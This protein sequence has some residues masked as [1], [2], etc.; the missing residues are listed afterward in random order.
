VTEQRSEYM[1]GA[2]RAV[3]EERKLVGWVLADH[4][5]GPHFLRALRV[6]PVDRDLLR[7]ALLIHVREH[8]VEGVRAS[9]PLAGSESTDWA[10]LGPLEIRG[11][12]AD[13]RSVWQVSAQGAPPR[14]I[15]AY[16]NQTR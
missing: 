14:L 3:V 16:P 5:H 1:P 10:V 13:V 8:P 6:E 12:S 15:T 11:R 9:H 2:E 4:G 7:S